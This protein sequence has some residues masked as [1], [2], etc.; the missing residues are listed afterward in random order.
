[1]QA[2]ADATS[3][4]LEPITQPRGRQETV[5]DAVLVASMGAVIQPATVL[6]VAQSVRSDAAVG[7]AG[8][9]VGHDAFAQAGQ[10]APATAAA[11]QIPAMAEQQASP[12][13][14]QVLSDHRAEPQGVDV[15][16]G[17]SSIQPEVGTLFL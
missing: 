10:A 9:R 5:R 3:E 16:S 13:H 17:T 4:L 12:A 15:S 6:A 7:S 8:T 11:A 14:P 1:M 2:A